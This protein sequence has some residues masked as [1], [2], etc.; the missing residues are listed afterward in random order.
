MALSEKVTVEREKVLDTKL[1]F[2]IPM[3]YWDGR[4]VVDVEYIEFREDFIKKLEESGVPSFYSDVVKSYY[5]GR[6]YDEELLTI[7]CDN[8]VAEA[9]IQM[10]KQTV[11]AWAYELRQESYAYEL[12]SSLCIF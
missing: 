5:K 1:V 4:Q 7:F 3:F 12:N 6:K 8:S 2:H 11:R 10:F 9:Y